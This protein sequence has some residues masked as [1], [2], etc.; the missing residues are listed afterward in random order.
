[1]NEVRVGASSTGLDPTHKN[2]VGPFSLLV[3]VAP[4][5][6]RGWQIGDFGD[7]EMWR[8]VN[9]IPHVMTMVTQWGVYKVYTPS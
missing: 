8:G 4:Q 5:G 1:M 7:L 9:S 3:S 6:H 2:C